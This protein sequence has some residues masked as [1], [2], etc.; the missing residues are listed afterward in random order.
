MPA[1]IGATA[2]VIAAQQEV[3]AVIAGKLADLRP[4]VVVGP[5]PHDGHHGHELVGRSIRD[6]VEERGKPSHAMFWG[7]WADLPLPNVLVAFGTARLAEIKRALGAHAGELARNRLDRL[8]EGRAMANAVLGPER[9]F[10]FGAHGIDETYAEL[11]TH[12]S[13]RPSDGWRLTAPR[14]LEPSQLLAFDDG[15]D[16]AWW[17]H[18]PSVRGSLRSGWP[19]DMARPTPPVA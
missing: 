16:I 7:V 3:A 14:M 1:S 19:G 8:L 12:V 6:A 2:N 10:G 9:V 18:A 5:S 13:W 15:P 4:E 17:L 11:L